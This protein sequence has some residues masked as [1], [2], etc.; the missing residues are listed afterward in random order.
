MFGILAPATVSAASN[1]EVSNNADFSAQ[2][3]H[4][5]GGDNIFVRL[6]SLSVGNLKSQLNLRDSD[7]NLVNTFK[8]QREGSYYSVILPAPYTSGY[9]SLEA[10]VE[11]EGA[12]TTS[13]KTIKVGNPTSANVSVHVNSSTRGQST[14]VLGEKQT[15]SKADSQNSNTSSAVSIESPSPSADSVGDQAIFNGGQDNPSNPLKVI[16]GFFKTVAD[17][18]WPFN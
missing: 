5:N 7:Y 13:V 17:F 16:L 2:T 8:L 3:L 11:S 10:Q 1:L 15:D 6:Q 12:S 9:Y 18:L 14:N 4:F